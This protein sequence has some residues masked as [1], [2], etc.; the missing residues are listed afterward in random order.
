[1]IFLRNNQNVPE[2][3]VINCQ[4]NIDTKYTETSTEEFVI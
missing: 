2:K 4:P 3:L 1:M